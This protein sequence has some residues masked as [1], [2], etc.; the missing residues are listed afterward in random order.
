MDNYN[1]KNNPEK[2]NQQLEALQEEFEMDK[3]AL[4]ARVF[5]ASSQCRGTNENFLYAFGCE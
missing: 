1:N 3:K 5:L 4:N 2:E